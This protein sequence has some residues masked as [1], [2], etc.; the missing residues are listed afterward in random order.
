MDD[1]NFTRFTF[2]HSSTFEITTIEETLTFLNTAAGSYY[3]DII[4]VISGASILWHGDLGD[5]ANSST[6]NK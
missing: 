5:Q 6:K 1:S 4:K 2:S 3:Y